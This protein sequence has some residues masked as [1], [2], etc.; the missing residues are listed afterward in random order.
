MGA[1]GVRMPRRDLILVTGATGNVGREVVRQLLDEGHAVR[2]LARDPESAGLPEAAEVVQGDLTQ[3]R[4]L[5]PALIGVTAVF[6]VWPALPLEHAGPAVDVLAA[7]T[8]RVVYLSSAGVDDGAAIQGDPINRFHAGVERLVEKSGADWTFLRCTSFAASLLTWG[9]QVRAGVVREAFGSS[10]RT[11]IHERDIAAV[12][13]RALTG[14]TYTGH[15]LMLSGPAPLS[16]IEQVR[17]IGEVLGRPVAF[18][19][20]PLDTLR[21]EMR[22]EGWRDP[23]IDGMFAAYATMA[24]QDQP[25]WDT[26][27]QITGRPARTFRQWVVD[28]AQDFR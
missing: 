23:D 9:D 28:H 7:H 20:I 4:T 5:R 27:E 1:K 10:T 26:V 16:Q 2:A 14:G 18:E 6:L 15:R 17:I 12:A 8:G 24:E 13:V 22:A 3:P 25:V 19:E 11:L 21:D